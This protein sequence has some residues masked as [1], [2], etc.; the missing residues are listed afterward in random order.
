MVCFSSAIANQYLAIPMVALC[1]L[2]V[3]IFDKVYMFFTGLFLLLH[4]QAIGMSDKFIQVRF[5][6]TSIARYCKIYIRHSYATACWIL[7]FALIY[8]IIKE[9]ARLR[10]EG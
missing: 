1:V 4:R 10:R 7:L 6:G 3:G 5:K 8:L 9:T 2:D